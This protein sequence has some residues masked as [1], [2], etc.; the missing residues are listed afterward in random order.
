MA[1]AFFQERFHRSLFHDEKTSMERKI[2]EKSMS[3]Y[4]KGGELTFSAAEI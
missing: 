3:G 2:E 4:L 1:K